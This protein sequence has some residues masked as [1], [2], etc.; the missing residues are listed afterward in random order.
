MQPPIKSTPP[1]LSGARAESTPT[2][3]ERGICNKLLPLNICP[4][5][6]KRPTH[7]FACAVPR[8]S[9]PIMKVSS[10][11]FAISNG[12]SPAAIAKSVCPPLPN[13][14]SRRPDGVI[15]MMQA[16]DGSVM[17]SH[18]ATTKNAPV[19]ARSA[20]IP[21]GCTLYVLNA[22]RATPLIPNEMSVNPFARKRCTHTS[23]HE[24]F[25][26]TISSPVMSRNKP[27]TRFTS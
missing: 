10:T 13:E 11:S 2:L 20:V 3:T 26:S 27:T 25:V 16:D 18:F 6:L 17:R 21:S 9:A 12:K 22:I 19:D 15:F 8:Q 5:E 7:H 23:V 24:Q 4:C 1:S 14:V